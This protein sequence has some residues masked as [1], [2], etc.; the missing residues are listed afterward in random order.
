MEP[1]A[2]SVNTV[3]FGAKNETSDLQK[4]QECWNVLKRAETCWNVLKLA[5]GAWSGRS[6]MIVKNIDLKM[7]PANFF[8][9]VNYRLHRVKT[10]T[11]HT[12]KM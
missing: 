9:G 11:E 7:R 4:T 6:I 10:H 1:H 8:C 5:D 12:Q 2:T 3:E